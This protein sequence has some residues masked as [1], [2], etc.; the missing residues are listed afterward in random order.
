ML[1]AVVAAA[2][3]VVTGSLWGAE[4]GRQMPW[5]LIARVEVTGTRL[6]APHEVLAASGIQQG[7]HLLDDP[8]AWEDALLAHPVIANAEITRKPPRTIRI[9]VTEKL[10]VALIGDGTLRMATATGEILPVD[11]HAAP[12]DLPILH[13]SMSDSARAI[14]TRNA[15]AEIARLTLLAPT[16]MREVSEVR[17]AG[18]AGHSLLLNH[19]AADI[20]IPIG[21]GPIR[22][23]ELRRILSDLDDRFPLPGDG[24]SRIPKHR[25]DLRFDGQVVVRP[26]NSGEHS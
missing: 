20:L 2:G 10:P 19:N 22:M 15:L 24:S 16:L 7:Q 18:D 11:P 14:N 5:L 8:V 3:L 25:V 1:A 13:G 23:E 6:L 21:A 9:R 12:M 4:L 17:L 26:S